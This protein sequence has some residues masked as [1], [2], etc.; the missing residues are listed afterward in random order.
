MDQRASIC[1]QCDPR[2]PHGLSRDVITWRVSHCS[3][4]FLEFIS[5]G[6]YSF[7]GPVRTNVH[8]SRFLGLLVLGTL[9]A[10]TESLDD[11][12]VCAHYWLELSYKIRWDRFL[13]DGYRGDF[14]ALAT[15][16]GKK[17]L[18]TQA[19]FLFWLPSP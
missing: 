17:D 7:D 4:F 13:I 9:F 2:S 8:F 14:F 16:S 1:G 15:E 5:D 11:L 19:N 6:L 18:L 12:S 10:G 3:L